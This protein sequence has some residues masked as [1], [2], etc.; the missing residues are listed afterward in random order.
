[1]GSILFIEHDGELSEIFLAFFECENYEVSACSP[2]SKTELQTVLRAY[3]PKVVI[4]D[5]GVWRGGE[6]QIRGL[7]SLIWLRQLPEGREI[8]VLAFSTD[9][10]YLY[11]EK[12]RLQE[13]NAMMEPSPMD[14]DGLAA[15]VNKLL[16][17]DDP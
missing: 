1:M 17:S 7:E 10:D 4:V 14:F 9:T 15:A 13:L 8:P 16:G 3:K 2:G 11:R 6:Y 12:D 5:I